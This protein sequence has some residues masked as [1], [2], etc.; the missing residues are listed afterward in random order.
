MPDTSRFAGKYSSEAEDN[1]VRVDEDG[2][3]FI[4]SAPR[5]ISAELG[6][7][8]ETMDEGRARYMY[9]GRIARRVSE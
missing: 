3:V 7:Q 9:D 6:G 5:G 4:D 8:P 2:R 1:V